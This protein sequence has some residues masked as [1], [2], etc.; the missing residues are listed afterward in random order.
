MFPT[1]ARHAVHLN[2]LGARHTTPQFPGKI[3]H[4]HHSLIQCIMK[5]ANDGQ[6][7]N[8]FQRDWMWVNAH[9]ASWTVAFTI[10]PKDYSSKCGYLC[11]VHQT[12]K[13][14]V[15]RCP[16][17]ICK[18]RGSHGGVAA[19]YLPSVTVSALCLQLA[20]VVCQSLCQAVFVVM[21]SLEAKA[22]A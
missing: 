22:S 4:V 6:E 18:N 14:M 2:W 15:H 7:G 13:C 20:V 21:Q 8:S 12:C 9:A 5:F 19:N 3:Q 11:I 17:F 1:Q 16:A 10:Q